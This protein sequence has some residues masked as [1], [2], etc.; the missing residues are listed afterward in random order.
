MILAIGPNW[1]GCDYI[2]PIIWYPPDQCYNDYNL[3]DLEVTQAFTV[4][5]T[6]NGFM[7]YKEEVY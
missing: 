6:K 2:S 4:L 3:K 5:K 1:I 7:N